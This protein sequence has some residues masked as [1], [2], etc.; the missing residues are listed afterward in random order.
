MTKCRCGAHASISYRGGEKRCLACYNRFAREL[1]AAAQPPAQANPR[2]V[3]V[4]SDLHLNSKWSNHTTELE[5]FLT[6]LDPKTVAHLVLLG[7][8]FETWSWPVDSRPPNVVQALAQ[9]EVPTSHSGSPAQGR[10]G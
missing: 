7:D 4:V 9:A 3:I 5:G 2:K 6:S 10:G 1:R 8:I